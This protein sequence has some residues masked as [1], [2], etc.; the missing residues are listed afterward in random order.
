MNTQKPSLKRLNGHRHELEAKAVRMLFTPGAL[1]EQEWG[2]IINQLAPRQP[3][4][5]TVK[6]KTCSLDS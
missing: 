5:K 3:L 6:V 4:L 1:N 2:N